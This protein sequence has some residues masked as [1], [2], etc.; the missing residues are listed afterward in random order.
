MISGPCP[1]LTSVPFSTF[2]TAAAFGS[3]VFHPVRSFPLNSVTG[4][5]H[6]GLPF[7]WSSGAGSPDHVQVPPLGPVTDPERVFPFTFPVKIQSAGESSASLGETKAIWPSEIST[8]GR[9]RAF[10]QR[11]T[12]WADSFPSSSR[13]SNHEGYSRSGAFKVRSQR[14]KKDLAASA[15][16]SELPGSPRRLAE[17]A[18]TDTSMAT[19]IVAQNKVGKRLGVMILAQWKPVSATGF[20]NLVCLALSFVK[21]FSASHSPPP[22]NKLAM[23]FAANPW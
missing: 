6:L 16:G 14:P 21:L 12:I 8:L 5:P 17:V 15:F 18:E 10:P 13:I 4:L 1:G 22:G 7:L 3:L 20:H 23:A 19:K 11:P 9:G 2:Q